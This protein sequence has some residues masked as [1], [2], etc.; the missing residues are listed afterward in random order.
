[1]IQDKI[2][3]NHTC[4]I[5]TNYWTPLNDNDDENKEDEEEANTLK[6]TP[7]L[8]KQ[9]SNKWTMQIATR[10]KEH[11]II[12]NSSTTSHFT[13]KDLHLPPEGTYNKAVFLLLDNRQL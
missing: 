8:T 3:E 4:L 7:V 5:A 6:S 1:V 11:T 9:K 2:K 10:Q 13:S 12:I